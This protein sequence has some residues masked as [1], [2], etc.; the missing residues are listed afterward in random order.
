MD[1]VLR[2]CDEV[3]GMKRGASIE[4]CYNTTIHPKNFWGH[5]CIFY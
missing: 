4:C 1:G 2:A 5:S 3:C